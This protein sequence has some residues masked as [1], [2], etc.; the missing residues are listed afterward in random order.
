MIELFIIFCVV[1]VIAGI[2]GLCWRVNM[3]MNEPEKYERLRKFEKQ[4][5]EDYRGAFSRTYKP[6]APVAKKAGSVGARLLV[7][8]L[9]KRR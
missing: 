7:R 9:T 2:L 1:G 6:F 3:A 4:F 5:E 8:I